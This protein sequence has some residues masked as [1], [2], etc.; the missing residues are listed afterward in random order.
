MMNKNKMSKMIIAGFAAATL[1]LS[2]CSTYAAPQPLAKAERDAR[3]AARVDIEA[4]NAEFTYQLDSGHPEVLANFFTEDAS[5]GA[6]G[7]ERAVGRAAI[8]KRYMARPAG[9]ITHHVT[10]NLRLVFDS[11]TQAHGIRTLTYYAADGQPSKAA[12]PLGVADYTETYKLGTD[13][14]WRY[15]SRTVTPVFGLNAP[16]KST[17]TTVAK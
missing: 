16:E 11:P 3:R 2:A 7:G 6:A 8:T 5:L 15:S 10:S 17:D 12:T 1:M 4:L 13:G 14:E 9:R